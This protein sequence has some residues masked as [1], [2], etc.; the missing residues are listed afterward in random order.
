MNPSGPPTPPGLFQ[1]GPLFITPTF[2]IGSLGLD[3]NVF[4]TATDRHTD[5]VTSGGPGLDLQVPIGAFFRLY[6]NGAINYLFFLRTPS[7]R[8][9]GGTT[10]GGAELNGDRFYFKVEEFYSS[11]FERPSFEV[12]ERIVVNELDTRGDFR[13]KF[14]RFHIEAKGLYAQT[15]V[16]PGTTY[17]GTDL[18]TTMTRNETLITLE[19]G[20]ELTPKTTFVIGGDDELD[21]FPFEPARD[22]DSNRA[23]GG[24]QI[25]SATRLSGRAVG[26]VRFLSPVGSSFQLSVPYAAVSLVYNVSPKTEFLGTYTH[27]L[28][29]SAFN[30]TGPTPVITNEAV[31]F[32]FNQALSGNLDLRLYGQ[33]SHLTTNGEISLV[34][35][36]TQTVTGVK[37]DIVWDGGANIGYRFRSHFRVGVGATY[38][39]RNSTFAYFGIQGLVVGATVNYDPAHPDIHP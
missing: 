22:A 26:G 18:G 31:G 39:S 11:L 7:Q 32:G 20:Y 4:Y 37:D 19:L 13:W 25:N 30:M 10:Y 9:L 8:K 15:S 16:P 14:D 38:V 29:F 36:P 33:R 23:Y 5:F 3:S 35:S 28:N 1:L 17:L 21:R 6:A 12:D 2:H 27:D 24:F 34:F